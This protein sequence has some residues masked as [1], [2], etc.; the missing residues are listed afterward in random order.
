ML[1][2]CVFYFFVLIL[3]YFFVIGIFNKIVIPL[4]FVGYEIVIANSV[5][6]DRLAIYQNLLVKYIIVN[7]LQHIQHF[8]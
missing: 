1:S 7:T 5:L 3:R 4:T 8:Q 2:I 6:S